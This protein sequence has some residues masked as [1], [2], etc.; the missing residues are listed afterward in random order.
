MCVHALPIH[1]VELLLQGHLRKAGTAGA[2]RGPEDGA[3][4]RSNPG[5]VAAADGTAER[6][7]ERGSEDRCPH[8]L[9]GRGISLGRGL[10]RGILLAVRLFGSESFERLIRPGGYRN[11][12]RRGRRDAR[13]QRDHHCHS[14]CHPRIDMLHPSFP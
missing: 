7:A 13:A 2:D 12:R 3:R 5:T 9:I 10:R 11:H 8:G 4:S 6:R 14:A 1:D